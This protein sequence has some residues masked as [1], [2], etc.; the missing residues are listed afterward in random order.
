[1]MTTNVVGVLVNVAMD[2]DALVED[3]VAD[4]VSCW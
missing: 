1:M 4:K 2:V 3:G